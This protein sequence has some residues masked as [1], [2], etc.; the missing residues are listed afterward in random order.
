[1]AARLFIDPGTFLSRRPQSGRYYQ[2]IDYM[3][4]VRREPVR[5]LKVSW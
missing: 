5:V 3:A 2:T 1:M 4:W